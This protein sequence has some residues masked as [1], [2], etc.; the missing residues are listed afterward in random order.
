MAELYSNEKFPLGIGGQFSGKVLRIYRPGGPD[1]SPA[2]S[3]LNP[4]A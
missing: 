1:G 4:A 2:V 3:T